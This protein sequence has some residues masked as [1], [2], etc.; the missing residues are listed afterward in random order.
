MSQPPT[1]RRPELPG[2]RHYFLFIGCPQQIM[3]P[4]SEPRVTTN[5]ELHFSQ[6]YLL[7]VSVANSQ[8]LSGNS[9]DDYIGEV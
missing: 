5:S 6:K 4:S 8:Y 7:P 9:I 2:R 1:W 3:S